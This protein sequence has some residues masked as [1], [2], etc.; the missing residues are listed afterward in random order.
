[1]AKIACASHIL[2]KDQNQAQEIKAKLTRG[3]DFAQLA[4]RFSTCPSGKKGGDLGEFRK[5]VMAQPF[6]QAVFKP[7]SENKPFLGPIKSRFGYHL[8]QVLYKD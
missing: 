8:I 7:G 2:V 3:D 6:D 5:G 4:R 1:M